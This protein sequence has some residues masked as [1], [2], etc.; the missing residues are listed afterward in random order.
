[1][2]TNYSKGSN[3]FLFISNGISHRFVRYWIIDNKLFYLFKLYEE[4][5]L[6]LIDRKLSEFVRVPAASLSNL[7]GCWNREFSLASL[8]RCHS[9]STN[10]N[11]SA[12]YEPLSDDEWHRFKEANE[13]SRFQHPFKFDRL[14]AGTL[15]NSDN[16]LSINKSVNSSYNLKR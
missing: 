14:A 12:T 11:S 3:D 5:T 15:T 4:L 8:K 7:K 13:N 9:S 10:I 6:L 1:M 2:L 16:F